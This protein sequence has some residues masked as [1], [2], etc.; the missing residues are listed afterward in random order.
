MKAGIAVVAVAA[1]L[2]LSGCGGSADK[3]QAVTPT[4]SPEPPSAPSTSAARAATATAGAD[5]TATTAPTPSAGGTASPDEATRSVQGVWLAAQG[6]TKVQLVLGNG[7][8]DLT[9]THL[10][11]GGYTEKSG[12]DITL[13]CMDGDRERTKGQGV[14]APDGSTLTVQWTDG[15]TDVFTRTG[16]P[17]D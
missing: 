15:P 6:D 11:G 13:T 8:A 5:G 3:R 10:C 2:L 7:E 16:L 9:G 12:V 14:L 1:A 17:S 4:D